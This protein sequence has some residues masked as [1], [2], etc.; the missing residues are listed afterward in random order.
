LLV[1]QPVLELATAVQEA[2]GKYLNLTF[3]KWQKTW[4]EW[5]KVGN[6]KFQK[7]LFPEPKGSRQVAWSSCGWKTKS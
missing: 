1:F 2:K 4:R 5:R 6:K 3:R 7:I